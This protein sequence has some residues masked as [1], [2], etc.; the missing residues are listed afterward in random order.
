MLIASD[1][2][3]AVSC[4]ASAAIRVELFADASFQTSGASDEKVSRSLAVDNSRPD[5][6]AL[7]IA[8]VASHEL[9]HARFGE[10]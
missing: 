4:A 6:C 3:A 10:C 5:L 2:A 9:K 1:N 7:S 8:P